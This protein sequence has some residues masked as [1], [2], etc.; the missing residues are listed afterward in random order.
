MAIANPMSTWRWLALRLRLRLQ[1]HNVETLMHRRKQGLGDYLKLP[2][3]LC[4]PQKTFNPTDDGPRFPRQVL[5]PCRSIKL[6]SP[7]SEIVRF[8]VK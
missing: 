2:L 6:E 3:R 7:G 8:A 4:Q 5:D 1:P